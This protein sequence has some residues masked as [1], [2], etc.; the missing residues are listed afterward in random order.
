MSDVAILFTM[1]LHIEIVKDGLYSKQTVAR[2]ITLCTVL[3][4]ETGFY[5]EKMP[6]YTEI[7]P[8]LNTGDIFLTN[9]NDQLALL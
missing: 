8:D 9:G 1:S 6:P 2:T 5:G 3:P 4:T 7:G